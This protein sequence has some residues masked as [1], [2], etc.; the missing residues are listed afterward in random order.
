[1]TDIFTSTSA[2]FTMSIVFALALCASLGL[3]FWLASR[4][5]RHVARHRA[6]VPSAFADKISLPAHQKAADY[7]ISKTQFGVLELAWGATTTL[8]WTLMGGLH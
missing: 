7:T 6:S 4:Q 2:A 1:M 8:G 5:I 3:K